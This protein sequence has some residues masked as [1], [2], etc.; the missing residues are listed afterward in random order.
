MKLFQSSN[1]R[2]IFKNLLRKELVW[3]LF[4]GQHMA[5]LSLRRASTI[6]FRV[7]ML[8]IL[9][10]ALAALFI[11]PD[12]LLLP[13]PASGQ[14]AAGRLCACMAFLVLAFSFQGLS[15]MRD[16]YLALGTLYVIAAMFYAFALLSQPALNEPGFSITASHAF[17]PV[18][19]A[20]AVGLFPLTAAEAGIVATA[21]LAV[22]LGSMELGSG[23]LRTDVPGT[24]EPVSAWLLIAVAAVAALS[25]IGQLGSLVALMRTA[26]RDTL[27]G[28]FSRMSGIEILD[29]QFIISSRS[30]APLSV[31]Y[32]ELDNMKRVRQ[33]FGPAAGDRMVAGA[34][35]AIRALLRT[36][37][38]L[39][40]WG[41]E[42]FILIMPNTNRIQAVAAIE[43]ILASGLDMRPDNRP[44]TASIGV[45]ERIDD[46]VD[47]WKGLVEA[48]ASRMRDSRPAG[49]GRAN[50]PGR[51][52]RPAT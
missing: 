25:A 49:Q 46:E 51:V 34:A 35:N 9:F 30:S 39:A 24:A 22:Q 52:A 14:M 11:I 12:L 19:M 33:A 40:R 2:G 13:W 26:M 43:R 6:I 41:A 3:L 8:A 37:D 29:L 28:C 16:A 27:T 47:D 4:P 31:A 48:A 36:G 1:L 7:R 17:L 42:D 50:L 10:A 38:M 45:A 20:A 32:F 15:R 5:L 18:V 21:M 23:P 44:V